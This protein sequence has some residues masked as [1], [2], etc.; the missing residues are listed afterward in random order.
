MNGN[1]WRNSGLWVALASATLLAA[2]SIGVLVGYEITNEWIADVMV[3]VNA[4]LGVLTVA[5]VVSNPSQGSGFKDK[6]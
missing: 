2:Q 5:G 6:E 1:K 3:A 4:V